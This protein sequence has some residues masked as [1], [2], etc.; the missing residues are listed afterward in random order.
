MKIASIDIGTNTILLLIVE[1]SNG[2]I[3]SVVHDE[4]V[5]ARLGKGVDA[6]RMINRETFERAAGFL[7]RY[8]NTCDDFGVEKIRAV[9]TSALRDAANSD[10]FIS[11]IRQS[12]GISIEILTGDDE[13]RWTYRGGISEFQGRADKYSVI[14]IGGGSTEIIIGDGS[15]IHSK[16]SLDLGSVRLTER[17]LKTSP[18]EHQELIEAHD[19][20]HSHLR[21][22]Q[23]KEIASTYA[24]GVAGTLTTLAALHQRLPAYDRE[25]VSG[26]T[27][28]YVDVCAMFG[29]LKD[30]TVSQI[31]A[32]PQI[33]P[34][35]EDIIVA[36]IMILM[37]YLESCG[38]KK[39]T[40][41][42]R[43]LRYGM[44]YRELEND[45]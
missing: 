29:L 27:L 13:A 35:R 26:Y 20:I 9:G 17:I 1:V 21:G 15:A 10:E 30:K 5:I 36:G 37:G 8:K 3:T 24:V 34:G 23:T 43:G 11:F 2:K 39:I 40:V 45:R 19:V 16:V 31:S 44:I 18:P 12:I 14:D 41:S 42:D 33:S 32:L 4:Q 6:D 22:V 7:R 25:K 28:E 38:L